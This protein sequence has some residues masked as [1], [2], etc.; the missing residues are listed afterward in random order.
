MFE[1]ADRALG[2]RKRMVAA[3]LTFATVAAI[4]ALMPRE[5]ILFD[6]GIIL[7]AA[8]RVLAGE[9]P[10]RDFYSNYGPGQPFAV[11]AVFAVFGVNLL[12]ARVYGAAMIALCV[13]LGYLLLAGRVRVVVALF[14]SGIA[15]AWLIAG[16]Y[17]MYPIYP[18]L[19]LSLVS[20]MLLMRPAAIA[21]RWPVLLA[22]GCAGIAALFRYDTGFVLLL[23]QVAFIVLALPP[24][25]SLAAH[26]RSAVLP[27]FL[28]GIGSAITFSPFATSFLMV[29]PISAFTR[30]IVALASIYTEMR[31]LPFP[32]LADVM[33]SVVKVGIFFPFFI[34]GV[35]LVDFAVHRSQ[36]VDVSGDDRD[37]ALRRL[38]LVL[39]ILTALMIYKGLNRVSIIHFM[40]AIIPGV[41]LA[42]AMAERWLQSSRAHQVAAYLLLGA[43]LFPALVFLGLK[44]REVAR[45]FGATTLAWMV[46]VKDS[47]NT[48]P[49]DSATLL[50]PDYEAIRRYLV[51]NVPADDRILIGTSRHDRILINP[52][53]LYAHAGRLPATLWA[54]YDPGVQ[55]SEIVQ[56][57]MIGEL[58]RRKVRWIVRDATW[59]N[60]REPNGS[61]VSS[62]ITLLDDFIAAHYRPVATAGA[63]SVWLHKADPA[64]VIPDGEACL[65]Q[66]VTTA[67]SGR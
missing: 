2:P 15:A 46:G 30:D 64:P 10:H 18:C 58:E 39:A 36:F 16:G 23:A 52:I 47:G 11:A 20:A 65:P 5:P 14:V 17:L 50:K 37:R 56:R 48:C 63:L 4:V 66:Q 3:L 19:A 33:R 22:G 67:A 53:L 60:R 26:I 45:D 40:L 38:Q 55:T 28:A 9:I 51:R 24:Q 13:G 31:G 54:Q 8:M 57:D 35:A 49:Q 25:Q 59:E 41:L 21:E 43:T 1:W 34:A 42:G 6:D 12:A 27:C 29:S 32:S 7:T 44:L 61:A 62:G